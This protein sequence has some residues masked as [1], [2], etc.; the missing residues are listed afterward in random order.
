MRLVLVCIGLALVAACSPS[1]SSSSGSSSSAKH[2]K[3]AVIPKGT[4]HEFW[5]AVEAGARKADL[6]LDDLEIVWKG[7]A[8]EGDAAAQIALVESFIADR[9]DGICLAPLD[10]QALETPVKTAIANKIPVVLFD[11]GLSRTDLGVTSFVA[12]DNFHGGQVAGEELTRILK[13]RG[14]VVLMRY[15]VGSESTEQREKGFIDAATVAVNMNLISFDRHGGPDEAKAIEVGE[16]LL[17]T[18]GA[19]MDGMFCAN[20]SCTSGMITALRRD[21]RHLAGKIKLIGFDSSANIVDAMK[22]GVLYG[23]VL[24]DPVQMG[25]RAV[26]AMHDKLVGKPVKARIET[27]ETLATKDNMETERV[28]ALLFP[29]GSK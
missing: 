24:Q 8:G 17:A 22:E 10:A 28:H 20:E 19:Q 21:P 25:Y 2:F 7:P 9:Y 29:L 3:V 4:S 23:T 12:T 11:S 15:Q 18:F 26:M 1:T 5:K 14:N 13:A 27:G 16:N 6:E